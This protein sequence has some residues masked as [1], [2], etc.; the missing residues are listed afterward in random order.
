MVVMEQQ[1]NSAVHVITRLIVAVMSMIMIGEYQCHYGIDSPNCDGII[2]TS[3][4]TSW[5]VETKSLNDTPKS[6]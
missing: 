3:P 1:N 6:L 5:L 2:L 4:L